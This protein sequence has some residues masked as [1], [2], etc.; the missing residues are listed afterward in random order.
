MFK[1]KT[2]VIINQI[3]TGAVT[4]EMNNTDLESAINNTLNILLEEINLKE[5]V[6]IEHKTTYIPETV[7]KYGRVIITV[8]YREIPTR[9]VLIE[10][11]AKT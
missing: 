4:A 11:T 5:Y 1:Q 8:M 6:F 9:K 3:T 2:V 7:K 10:K